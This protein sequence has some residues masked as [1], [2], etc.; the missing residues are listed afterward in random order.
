MNASQTTTRVA[1]GIAIR[2]AQMNASN[3]TD[4]RTTTAAWTIWSADNPGLA[5]FAAAEQFALFDRVINA[6]MDGKL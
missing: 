5:E 2:A 1:E 3:P 6:Q 4:L